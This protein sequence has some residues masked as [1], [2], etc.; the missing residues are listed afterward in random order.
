MTLSSDLNVNMKV[1]RRIR[2][3][4]DIDWNRF[5]KSFPSIDRLGGDFLEDL[6]TVFGFSDETSKSDSNRQPDHPGSRNADS[7]G[8]LNNVAA[9]TKIDFFG[10]HT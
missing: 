9:K 6:E 3:V 1:R 10:L 5:D 7:H 8:V 2:Q 4:F